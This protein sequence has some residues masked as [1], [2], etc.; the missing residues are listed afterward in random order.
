MIVKMRKV[1]LVAP[2]SGRQE[3]LERLQELGVVHLAGQGRASET[4]EKLCEQKGL[5]ERALAALPALKKRAVAAAHA[6]CPAANLPCTLQ[7][8]ERIVAASDRIRSREEELERLR[9]ETDR[10]APWGDFDPEAVRALE[11]KG[12]RVRLYE[13][14]PDQYHR[15]PA[16]ARHWVLSISREAVRLAAIALEG[17]PAPATEL[18]EYPPPPA[19]PAELQGRIREKTAE[20]DGLRAE[21]AAF[22]G[23]TGALRRGVVELDGR[24]EF[25]Q[26]RADMGSEGPLAWLSGFVPVDAVD[27]LKAAAAANGWALL[28]D[29]PAAD[30]AVPTLIRN[31]RWVQIINPVFRIL[32]TVPGYGEYDISMWFLLSFSLFFGM[33]IG[34]AAYGLLFLGTT[35]FLHWKM[36][37]KPPQP[38]ILLYVLSGATIVWGAMTGTWFGMES[39]ARLP[40]FSW[41]VVPSISSWGG[42]AAANNV[43]KFAFL[44]GAVHLTVAHGLNVVRFFPSPKAFANFGWLLMVWGMYFLVLFIVMHQPLF[45]LAPWLV[46]AGFLIITLFEEQGGHFLKGVGVGL[47]KVPLKLLSSISMFADI[48]S[49]VRLFAVGLATVS[50]ATA[51]NDMALRGGWSFPGGLAAALILL[52]GHALNIVMGGMSI[53]VHGV[54]LNML[55]FSGHLGIEWS[56]FAYRPFSKRS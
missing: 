56:G 48:I 21:M 40:F 6:D 41:F 31:P 50:I 4:L 5:L 12:V 1:W 7:T 2:E 25:E 42:T 38:F 27:R 53:V 44:I 43:M 45:W 46:G 32:E 39:L 14:T 17:E 20:L 34:D 8:A 36:R 11:R 10:F 35:A 24:Q 23:E 28:V 3:A 54:R 16:G 13:L 55:E 18:P 37:D 29:E 47:A 19:G 52:L 33:L 51:F 30:E 26:A 49:Y 15:F 9:R 22:E